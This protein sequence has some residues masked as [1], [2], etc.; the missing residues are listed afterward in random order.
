VMCDTAKSTCIHEMRTPKR[1]GMSENLVE[2]LFKT[3]D[4]ALFIL[5]FGEETGIK[6]LSLRVVSEREAKKWLQQDENSTEIMGLLNKQV[7]SNF[8]LR[9]PTPLKDELVIMA[10]KRGLR[11]HALI[12]ESL[13]ESIRPQFNQN[14][15]ARAFPEVKAQQ[16]CSNLVQ[17][18]RNTQVAQSNLIGELESLLRNM[19][20]KS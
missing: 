6:G 12:I 18:I 15:K 4:E 10:E 2:Q 20:L 19:E 5:S 14:Q 7:T 9:L 16:E 17:Q 11:L 3:R 1:D 13:Q 8:T